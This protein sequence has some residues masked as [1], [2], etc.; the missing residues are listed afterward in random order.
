MKKKISLV[1]FKKK[2]SLEFQIFYEMKEFKFLLV[3]PY[4]Q[5]TFSFSLSSLS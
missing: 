1:S 3:Y 2:S 4:P 5:L